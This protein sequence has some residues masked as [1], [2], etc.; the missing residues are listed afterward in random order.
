MIFGMYF[1]PQTLSRSLDLP[2]AGLAISA[3]VA[4]VALLIHP[5]IRSRVRANARNFWLP[6]ALLFS[7]LI[8]ATLVS[9]NIAEA[10]LGGRPGRDCFRS[11]PSR[12]WR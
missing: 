4:L 7:V 1:P 11:Q 6:L 10:V 5:E 8:V 2:R 12:S 9:G 3:V